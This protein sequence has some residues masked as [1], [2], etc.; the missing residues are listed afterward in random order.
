MA[1]GFLAL[2]SCLVSN[3]WQ[4]ED[5]R[6]SLDLLPVG[7]DV[8][9][10]AETGSNVHLRRLLLPLRIEACGGSI[11]NMDPA[12]L[13]KIKREGLAFLRSKRKARRVRP[14]IRYDPWQETPAPQ[15]WS[16]EGLWSGLACMGLGSDHTAELQEMSQSAGSFSTQTDHG[17]RLLVIPSRGIV[18]ATYDQ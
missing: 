1:L 3:A 9:G 10:H 2:I 4:A 16:S 14:P 18:L 8:H 11:M 7:I 12:T 5:D 15:E 13:S 17:Q 6:L